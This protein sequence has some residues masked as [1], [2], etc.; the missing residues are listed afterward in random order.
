MYI[1]EPIEESI[2]NPL[3]TVSCFL[4]TPTLRQSVITSGTQLPSAPQETSPVKRIQRIPMR[5]RGGQ[6]WWV[7]VIF[8]TNWLQLQL[9][10]WAMLDV[11]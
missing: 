11:T 8:V 6:Q 9:L 4:D 1:G 5:Q 10:F 2:F 3:L 7:I